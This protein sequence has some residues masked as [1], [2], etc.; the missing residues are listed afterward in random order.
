LSY[1]NDSS[2]AIIFMGFSFHYRS[3]FPADSITF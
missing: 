2:R 1:Q 3:E